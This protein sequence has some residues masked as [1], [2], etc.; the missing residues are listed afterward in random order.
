MTDESWR[1]EYVLND[2]GR[3]FYGTRLHISPM[4]WN[5]GQVRQARLEMEIITRNCLLILNAPMRKFYTNMYAYL[6]S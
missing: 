5:F 3:L 4:P 6:R 2:C 1:N